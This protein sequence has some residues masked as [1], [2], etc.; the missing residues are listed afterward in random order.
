MSFSYRLF[1]KDNGFEARLMKAF[2]KKKDKA[3]EGI[4]E[5][6]KELK[7]N[8][9][10][11]LSNKLEKQSGQLYSSVSVRS[12]KTSL[13]AT[14]FFKGDRRTDRDDNSIIET[15]SALA[16]LLNEGSK[17]RGWWIPKGGEF[18][19]ESGKNYLLLKFPGGKTVKTFSPVFH[20][21]LMGFN[22]IAESIK[23]SEPTIRKEVEKRVKGR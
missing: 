2:S 6:A 3:Y 16:H 15:N 13:S 5:G 4:K 22:F 1:I 12:D 18:P 21:G 17:K 11:L 9:K 20:P 19:T 14:I 7:R 23:M 8:L 10:W